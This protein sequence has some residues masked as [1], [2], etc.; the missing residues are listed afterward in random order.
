MRVEEELFLNS[1]FSLLNA[2]ILLL[3][4]LTFVRTLL[5]LWLIPRLRGDA[6]AGGPRVSVIIPARNEA[7]SIARTVRAFLAQSYADLELIVVD[8]RSTDETATIL[9]GI[10]RE[11]SRLR[12]LPGTE[13]PVGWLGKPWALH[14]GREIATGELLLFVDADIVYEPP[15]VAAAVAELQSTGAAMLTIFPCMVMQ[16]FWERVSMPMLAMTLYA[17]VPTWF[18]NRTRFVRLGLGAG[19]GN[20]IR[21][22]DYIAA[23][24]HEALRQAVVD[25]V[26]MARLLRR[27]G[28]RTTVARSNDLVSVRMYANLGEIVHGFTKNVFAAFGRSYVVTVLFLVLSLV[29]HVMPYGV[30]A[31]GDLFSITTVLLITVTRLVVFASLGYPLLYAVLA[32]PLM[33]MVWMYLAT[34]SAWL[35]GV[36]KQLAWRGRSYDAN[37]TRF[38]A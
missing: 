14:Q 29:L 4:V 23:G 18:S 20:L 33:V 27:H 30:A 26:G 17:F 13:T 6:P 5:N 31:T 7:G 3:W 24:G 37:R 25:D 32:H 35:T 8:D 10:A 15:A 21:R 36:K 1:P 28:R 11:D 16:S 2:I 12:V 34:R 22:S 38:G 19:T 9:Q